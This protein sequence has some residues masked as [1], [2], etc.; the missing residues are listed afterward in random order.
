MAL[1]VAVLAASCGAVGESSSE[2]AVGDMASPVPETMAEAGDDAEYAEELAFEVAAYD[3]P[4]MRLMDG[5]SPVVTQA[6]T[7]GGTTAQAPEAP[8]AQLPDLG[9]EIIYTAT[10]E[11]GSTDVTT[12][13]RDAV[14]AVEGLGGFLFSQDTYG[15][16]GASSVMVFKVMPEQFHATIERLGAIGSVRGQSISADDVTAVVVD[17]QSR[18]TT[19][20]ASVER[21][22][23]LLVDAESIDVVARLENQLLD[24][25]TSLEQLR[26]QLRTVQ[27]QVDL[28]TIT[29]TV[30]ELL[31]RPSLTIGTMAYAG[32]DAGFGCF[33]SRTVQS[34]EA[35]E[36]IS[37]CYRLTNTG[38]TDLIDLTLNDPVL[39]ASAASL[40]LVDGSITQLAPG[41]TVDLV[42]EIEVEES[43]KLRTTA[44]AV[45][46]DNE[47][48]PI[49]A[50]VSATAP[51]LRFDLIGGD[52]GFPSFGEALSSSW[53]A[54]KTI[55]VVIALVAVAIAPFLAV[56]VVLGSIGLWLF[57]RR[58]ARPQSSATPVPP[59]PPEPG[60]RVDDDNELV[61]AEAG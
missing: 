28:A 34:A 45:G 26:G 36:A 15:G 46:L 41:E 23:A 53:N 12:A 7:S 8:T 19:A 20:E 13:T 60:T 61:S 21:L 59:A 54:L 47:G 10:L 6:Q 33:D 30:T 31:N 9:R 18:I 52:D 38:D 57:R 51:R 39:G 2:N 50:E 58:P 11:L 4:V 44:N 40:V 43:F 22:R 56:A 49:D 48:N 17:L 25:E 3:S 35:G 55:A 14:R 37:I 32:H 27:S 5:D 1:L 42:Q 24:R 16:S 29:V